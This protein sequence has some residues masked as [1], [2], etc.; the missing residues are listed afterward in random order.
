MRQLSQSLD[1]FLNGQP[2]AP[3]VAKH[4]ALL[5]ARSSQRSSPS[6][7]VPDFGLG[8][9]MENARAGHPPYSSDSEPRMPASSSHSSPWLADICIGHR[10]LAASNDSHFGES[11][12]HSH[13]SSLCAFPPRSS[14]VLRYRHH[15]Q[16]FR[17]HGGKGGEWR[18]GGQGCS[19]RHRIP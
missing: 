14:S 1:A 2:Y 3:L 5:W 11:I 10:T 13:W 18:H 12:D 9:K 16:P 15:G 6:A 8:G 7:S 4:R 19:Y 17:R